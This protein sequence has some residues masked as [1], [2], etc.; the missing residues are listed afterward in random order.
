MARNVHVNITDIIPTGQ[1]VS[2]D[3]YE[4]T[5]EATWARAY[6]GSGQSVLILIIWWR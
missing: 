1:Q 4:L 5:F 2:G 6:Q 3:Q